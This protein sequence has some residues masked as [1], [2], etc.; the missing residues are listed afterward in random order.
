MKKAIALLGLFQIAAI[1]HAEIAMSVRINSGHNVLTYGDPVIAE[2]ALQNNGTSPTERPLLLWGLVGSSPKISWSNPEGQIWEFRS[3]QLVSL[4]VRQWPMLGPGEVYRDTFDISVAFTEDFRKAM[5]GYPQPKPQDRDFWGFPAPGVYTI[6]ASCRYPSGEIVKA[7]SVTISVADASEEYKQLV[8][9]YRTKAVAMIVL[10]SNTGD[11]F[12]EEG[13]ENLLRQL[14]QDDKMSRWHPAA[15]HYLATALLARAQR[16]QTDIALRPEVESL[17]REALTYLMELIQNHPEYPAIE[18]VLIRAGDLASDPMDEAKLAARATIVA[19]ARKR[20][21]DK[22]HS[23][24]ADWL[25]SMPR[26]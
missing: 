24:L 14:V 1:G 15:L 4:G 11:C 6:E 20:V 21:D 8:D 5:A 16:R 7:T 13:V 22:T 23:P 25:R 17:R 9:K 19:E 18:R 12:Y 10:G 2:I 3:S 26:E